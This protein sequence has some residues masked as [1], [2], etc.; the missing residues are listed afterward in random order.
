MSTPGIP[1]PARPCLVCAKPTTNRGGR[2]DQHTRDRNRQTNAR[3]AYYQSR[4]WKALRRSCLD[5][6][7]NQCVVCSDTYRLT[8]HHVHAR[9]QGG[10]DAIGNLA[11]LCGR[12]H[13]SLEAGDRT[14]AALL[15]EHL[16]IM[17]ANG[18]AS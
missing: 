9:E 15:R 4:E 16:Q 14:I 6:D 12:C 1:S 5:R 7:H 18:L 8:A 10:P 11:T 17:K 3:S 13:S 2:C